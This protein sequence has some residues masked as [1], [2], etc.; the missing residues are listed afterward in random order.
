MMEVKEGGD[1][2]QERAS[3]STIRIIWRRK[4]QLTLNDTLH[5]TAAR[6]CSIPHE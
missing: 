6:C 3:H 5:D 1:A 2:Y 4:E